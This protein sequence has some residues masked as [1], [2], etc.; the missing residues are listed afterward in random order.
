MTFL[1]STPQST[2]DSSLLY[3]N[4]TA[5]VQRIGKNISNEGHYDNNDSTMRKRID[6]IRP[7]TI[8]TSSIVT[9]ESTVPLVTPNIQTNKLKNITD[10]FSDSMASRNQ[11]YTARNA[12]KNTFNSTNS[13]CDENTFLS[14][15][16]YIRTANTEVL[17]NPASKYAHEYILTQQ[18]SKEG[19]L[20]QIFNTKVMKC[21]LSILDAILLTVIQY[22]Q[23]DNIKNIF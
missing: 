9:A 3:Q 4:D 2:F 7:K 13:L 19:Q 15:C 17:C 23:V 18:T 20:Q 1:K 21:K 16:D 12:T 5:S 10:K 11:K 14:N 22:Y 6:T 8:F